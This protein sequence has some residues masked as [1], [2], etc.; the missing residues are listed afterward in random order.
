MSEEHL[1]HMFSALSHPVRR[2]IVILLAEEGP[3]TYSSMLGRLKLETGTLNHHLSKLRGIVEQDK[4]R[5]YCLTVEGQVAYQAILRTKRDFAVGPPLAVRRK[6][7]RGLAMKSALGL[8]RLLLKPVEAF[9]EVQ[10]E[11]IPYALVCVFIISLYLLTDLL[12]DVFDFARSILELAAGIAVCSIFVRLALKKNL[13]LRRFAVSYGLVYLPSLISNILRIAEGAL[14]IQTGRM[15]FRP[16]P[17]V[18][19]QGSTFSAVIFAGLS[20]WGFGLL[21]LAI[22]ESCEVSNSAAFTTVFFSSLAST[23]VNLL[24]SLLI[25]PHPTPPLFQALLA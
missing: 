19:H 17:F 2:S 3:Q 15:F 11:L 20:L 5:K 21:L 14:G 22:R 10:R 18:F 23:W 25:F 24:I 6:M 7:I 12:I 4:D 16:F 13:S 1:D 8:E 9:K